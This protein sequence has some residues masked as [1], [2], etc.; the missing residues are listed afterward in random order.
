LLA[1]APAT[2][3]GSGTD[4]Q[5]LAPNAP[6]LSRN[7]RIGVLLICSSALFL[8]GLDITVVDVALP[9]MGR[10]LHAGIA[11]VDGRRLHRRSMPAVIRSTMVA[12]SNSANTP[13][14]CSIIRPAGEP[15]SSGS[16]AERSTTLWRSSS[17]AR[18]ESW[19]TLR[20][21]AGRIRRRAMAG[22]APADGL[23]NVRFSPFAGRC[24]NRLGR[25]DDA[26]LGMEVATA[27]AEAAANVA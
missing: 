20:D 18:W 5:L 23:R 8:V 2:V 1:R 14:I 25:V 26:V 10:E 15:V 6:E 17:S 22:L 16:V 4:V 7:R 27:A 12:C 19:C 21:M 9:S 3:A 24:A 13:S 11:A